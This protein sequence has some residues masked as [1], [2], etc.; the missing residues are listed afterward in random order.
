M[1]QEL[2]ELNVR[3]SV[4]EG[5]L[6]TLVATDNKMKGVRNWQVEKEDQRNRQK[7]CRAK[8][9]ADEMEKK[10][11]RASNQKAQCLTS[12]FP[13]VPSI[14]DA[15][16]DFLAKNVNGDP[17]AW[18]VYM[19]RESALDAFRFLFCL[20]NNS[21]Q[22]KWIKNASS[23][24]KV[25]RGWKTGKPRKPD[26]KRVTQSVVFP[27]KVPHGVWTLQSRE[28]Y[29]NCWCWK[30]FDV[31]YKFLQKYVVKTKAFTNAE[32][33]E[34]DF[35]NKVVP[36]MSQMSEFEVIPGKE[37]GPRNIDCKEEWTEEDA[38]R[39]CHLVAPLVAVLAE[40]FQNGQNQNIT[41][42]F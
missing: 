16:M 30:V 13:D 34:I 2:S 39:A 29:A 20:Y 17:V 18:F 28:K 37:W 14:C 40:T 35:F 31:A 21:F 38:K 33:Q 24:Y 6:R 8:K 11:S 15:M 1:K 7:D 10:L 26:R 3:L 41:D 19:I 12:D 27:S 4:L 42:Y 36:V 25:L 5:L 32:G 23:P 22:E 9:G